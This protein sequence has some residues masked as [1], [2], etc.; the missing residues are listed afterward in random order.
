MIRFVTEALKDLPLSSG[1]LSVFSKIRKKCILFFTKDFSTAYNAYNADSSDIHVNF[2]LQPVVIL[3]VG[4]GV[5]GVLKGF[6]RHL[7][8]EQKMKRAPKIDPWN[9][10]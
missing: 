4:G 1:T 2:G 3:S 6:L 10:V 7:D 8:V 9:D 5:R